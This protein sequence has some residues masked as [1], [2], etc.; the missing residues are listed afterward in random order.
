[1][2][3]YERHLGDYA[4]DTAHLSLLEH[5]VYT[6]LL[7]RYYA[8][9]QPIPADQAHRVARARTRDEK[10]A[11]DAVLAEFFV[12]VDGAYRNKRADAVIAAYQEAQPER[13]AKK[14]NGK[15][16]VRR[17]RERRKQLFDTL[18]EA[19]I[20]PDYDTA[21]A[22]LER[23]AQ[24][25]TE[26]GVTPPVTRYDTA[27]QSQSPV[28]SIPPERLQGADTTSEARAR[29]TTPPAPGEPTTTTAAGRACLAMRRGGLLQTNPSHP[30]LLAAIAEGATDA[31]W[32]HT[33]REAVGHTPPKG[34]AWVIATVRGRLADAANL[35]T[36]AA[37]G[38]HRQ[39]SPAPRLSAADRVLANVQRA[40]SEHGDGWPDEQ[41]ADDAIPG[42][43]VRLPG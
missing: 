30:S 11:V 4:R 23:M 2:N 31:M 13:E 21:T 3:Y 36:G 26:Q 7:D 8:T 19:G 1:M 20:V 16:R 42:E 5:G 22:D 18:R 41:P 39:P 24:R 15:E 6:L 14:A 43:A 17:H 9:E 28:P 12:L 35:P 37:H 33:A 10:A 38:T 27:N 29:A 32:E 40:Q 25:V 34:F